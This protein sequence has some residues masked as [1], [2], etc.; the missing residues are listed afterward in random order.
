MLEKLVWEKGRD[1]VG[2]NWEGVK[3]GT[4]ALISRTTNGWA[5]VDRL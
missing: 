2:S 3:I 1:V 4:R 5:Q